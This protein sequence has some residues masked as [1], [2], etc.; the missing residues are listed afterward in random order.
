MGVGWRRSYDAYPERWYAVQVRQ[1]A[2]DLAAIVLRQKGYTVFLP[3]WVRYKSLN[4]ARNPTA[5]ALFP[6]YL[7][8]RI[9]TEV[10]AKIVTTPAVIRIVGHGTT[11]VAV[12]DE[13]IQRIQRVGECGLAHEPWVY[14]PEGTR[15]QI[16]SGPLRG[17]QGVLLQSGDADR[18][19]L[20]VHLLS[21]SVSVTLG[22]DTEVLILPK[23]SAAAGR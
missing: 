3:T 4:N 16:Q 10:T 12:P 9:D 15:V 18:I 19:I 8:S 22:R 21:R 14:L 13:E 5:S 17:L 23:H 11:P 7:F 2:E 20:S 1:G 6:G